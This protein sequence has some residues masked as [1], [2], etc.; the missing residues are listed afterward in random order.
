MTLLAPWSRDDDERFS[1]EL[2][3]RIDMELTPWG[4]SHSPDWSSGKAP[5]LSS[6]VRKAVALAESIWSQE[7]EVV[8]SWNLPRGV[9]RATHRVLFPALCVDLSY[10]DC[11]E[12]PGSDCGE[13]FESYVE[14]DQPFVEALVEQRE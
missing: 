9:D 10:E 1:K 4:R 3:L 5:E 2:V 6:I 8:W 13:W 11:E 12:D 7:K 14:N